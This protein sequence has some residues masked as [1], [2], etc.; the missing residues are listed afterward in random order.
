MEL[1]DLQSLPK[2][3]NLPINSSQT[4]NSISSLEGKYTGLVLDADVVLQAQGIWPQGLKHNDYVFR[5]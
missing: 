3:V 4:L 1:N 5:F 2:S